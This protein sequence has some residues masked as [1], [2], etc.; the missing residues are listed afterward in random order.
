MSCQAHAQPLINAS[1][2]ASWGA[3]LGLHPI[4]HWIMAFILL[5]ASGSAPAS[6]PERVVTLAPHITEQL[7]AAGA[8]HT[9]VGT[10]ISSDY[11]ESV[12]TLPKVGDGAASINIETLISLHPDVVLA[13][14]ASGA[15]AA[16]TPLLKSVDIPITLIAPGRMDDIPDA[17]EQLGT[18]LDTQAA[19][20]SRASNIRETLAALRSQYAR[21]SPVSVYIEIGAAPLY[22]VGRDTLLNDALSTCGGFNI[23]RDSK[24]PALPISP[25]R[26]L[27]Q[28]PQLILIATTNPDQLNEAQARWGRLGL[29]PTHTRIYGI[30]P[31][32]LFRPGPRLV[33]AT[34]AICRYL[35][36]ARETFGAMDTATEA[37]L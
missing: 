11:P 1:L 13:W 18:L 19:A 14:Q 29:G 27:H 34:V 6:A 23:F 20:S 4:R 28:R 8:G 26:V 2:L 21:K 33:D 32:A 30:N 12:K 10:V 35:E 5:F 22:A 37:N 25:E 9:L 15:V 24:L 7:Y 16:A 36:K 17:I 31:D 3:R